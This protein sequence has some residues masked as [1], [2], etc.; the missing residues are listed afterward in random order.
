MAFLLLDS[1]VSA[2]I[3]NAK[4][5]LEDDGGK[6]ESNILYYECSKYTYIYIYNIQTCLKNTVKR[7]F[8]KNLPKRV[9]QLHQGFA[10]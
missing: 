9:N 1:L 10:V 5:I 4:S 6:I 7:N 2:S 8:E 3:K